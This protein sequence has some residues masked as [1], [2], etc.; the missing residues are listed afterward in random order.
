MIFPF[1]IAAILFPPYGVTED[2]FEQHFAVNYLAHFLLTH[3]LLSR[4]V[5]A[6]HI[7]RHASRIVS[8]SSDSSFLGYLNLDDLQ[9]KYECTIFLSRLLKLISLISYVTCL[10]LIITDLR[11]MPS[12]NWH[13]LCLLKCS[14]LIWFNT[15]TLSN[16]MLFILVL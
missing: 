2:G 7:N 16:A 10:G 11:L 3:L 9:A 4:L 6:G 12:P 14:I 5:E 15:I 13:K 8:V 1:L